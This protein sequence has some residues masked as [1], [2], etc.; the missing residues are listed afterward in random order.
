MPANFA[1][2][3]N[4]SP[5]AG[6]YVIR[7]RYR[8]AARGVTA[9]LLAKS[10]G[11]ITKLSIGR[12]FL[13]PAPQFHAGSPVVYHSLQALSLVVSSTL[14][15]FGASWLPLSFGSCPGLLLNRCIFTALVIVRRRLLVAAA[16]RVDVG[17]NTYTLIS[18]LL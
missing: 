3:S 8:H 14:L 16:R 17:K 7:Y 13:M 4:S 11:T 12:G 1:A 9:G 6:V 5:S 15:S 10:L 2:A 18:F